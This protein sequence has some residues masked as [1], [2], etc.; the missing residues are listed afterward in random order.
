[1]YD[2]DLMWHTHQLF[3]ISYERDTTAILGYL[4]NHDDETTDRSPGSKL[5]TSDLET[6][7]LWEQV[8]SE[9]FVIP[10]VLNRGKSPVGRL[11]PVS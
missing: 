2:V 4:L 1:M 7:A 10:G 6:R 5:A 9:N 8:Y 11:F 3:P